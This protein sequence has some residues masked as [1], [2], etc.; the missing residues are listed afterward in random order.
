MKTAWMFPGQGSQQLDMGV[1]L[2]HTSE[3]IPLFAEA[4]TILGWSVIE[5]A[6]GPK[7]ILDRTLYTQPALF[8]ICSAMAQVALAKGVPLPQLVAGHSLGEYTALW[9]AGV[10][11][12]GTGL[13]LVSERARLMDGQQA[14]AMAALIGFDR[15][16]LESL[17]A[18]KPGVVIANDNSPMQVVISGTPERVAEVGAASKAKRVI[19]LAVSGAFHSPLMTPAATAF[20]QVLE[21]VDFAPAKIP[22]LCNVKP[23]LST[24][25]PNKIKARLQKQIDHP[26]RWRET[27]LAM[28]DM[29]MTELVEVGPGTVLTGLA[30]KMVPNLKLTNLQ[31][32][33]DVLIAVG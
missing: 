5:I 6:K 4:E 21:R 16:L 22:V 29:G 13:R 18:E 9:L 10:F 7:E 12:F 20:A 17:C 24:T 32:P 11:D 33:A 14:G 25:D 31:I 15:A 30:K 26:V 1:E 3:A 27:V 8:T 28:A 2:A 19:P 23:Q